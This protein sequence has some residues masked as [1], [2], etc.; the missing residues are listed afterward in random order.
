MLLV[1]PSCAS[2]YNISEEK[3][4]KGR[5]VRCKR[6]QS[7]WYASPPPAADPFDDAVAP[8]LAAAAEIDGDKPALDAP[9]LRD[10]EEIAPEP[11]AFDRDEI[12]PLVDAPPPPDPAPVAEPVD[13]MAEAADRPALEVDAV[14]TSARPEPQ[15]EP[16]LEPAAPA[17]AS[18]RARL[19]SPLS[20]LFARPVRSNRPILPGW[21][22]PQGAAALAAPTQRRGRFQTALPYAAFAASCAV[23]V[24]IAARGPIAAAAPGAAR[25][26]AALGFQ[27]AAG[28]VGVVSLKSEIGSADGADVLMVEGELV[29]RAAKLI[30]VPPLK[31]VVRDEQGAELYAWPAQSLKLA[32]EPGERTVFR[33][34]LA[35]PPPAGRTVQIRFEGGRSDAPP[36]RTS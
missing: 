34:R 22:P 10:A 18:W 24:A 25:L 31:V 11:L 29:S 36:P 9:S 12:T 20:V 8:I 2:S 6:C 15:P 30:D 32:L 16:A 27:D 14:A 33:A 35:A 26:Y 7:C 21:S 5:T 3:L 23:V 17:K 1:C 19:M 13:F 28:P 4:G